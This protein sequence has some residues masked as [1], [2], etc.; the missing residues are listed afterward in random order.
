MRDSV[1]G[2]AGEKREE[3]GGHG[4]NEA[5]EPTAHG[6]GL[7]SKAGAGQ[8]KGKGSCIHLI[9]HKGTSAPVHLLSTASAATTH[10][11]RTCCSSGNYDLTKPSWTLS[12][13]RHD[14]S[15]ILSSRSLLGVL[16]AS[17]TGTDP[18]PGPNTQLQAPS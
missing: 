16:H 8:G 18:G 2:P 12:G 7:T 15:L 1:V 6:A 9:W 14:A 13:I 11:H 3:E 5:A 17:R 10:L 4:K